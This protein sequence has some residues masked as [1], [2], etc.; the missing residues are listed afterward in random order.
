[1]PAAAMTNNETPSELSEASRLFAHSL[2]GHARVWLAGCAGVDEACARMGIDPGEP[3]RVLDGAPLVMPDLRALARERHE[4]GVRLVVDVSVPTPLGCPAARLG[5]DV[6]LASLDQELGRAHAGAV[7]VGLRREVL[8][9]HAGF[10]GA[11]L[12]ERAL[13]LPPLA[14][15]CAH[16]L[17]EGFYAYDATRRLQNDNAQVLASY[18]ACH[19]RVCAVSYPGLTKDPGYKAGASNLEEGFGCVIGLL[20]QKQNLLGDARERDLCGIWQPAGAA[21]RLVKADTS[22]GWLRL[23]CGTGDVREVALTLEQLL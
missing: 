10:A 15:R 12:L 11:S 2:G 17:C 9:G 14:K 13:G 16:E 1:M 19:P 20:P 22:P 5:A 4:R 6:I 23:L 18:L 3:V 7:M 21:S 8:Q